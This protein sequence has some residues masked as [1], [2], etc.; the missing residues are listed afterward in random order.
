MFCRKVTFLWDIFES[1]TLNSEITELRGDI[2][3]SYSSSNPSVASVDEN[4]NI[5]ATGIGDTVI[6]ISTSDGKTKKCE[7][8]CKVS[9][10][11]G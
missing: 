5:V 11:G 9:C 2:D 1:Y 3:V 7:C 6:T 10:N 4:G 8:E